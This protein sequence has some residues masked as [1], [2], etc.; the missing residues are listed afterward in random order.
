MLSRSTKLTLEIVL[1][2]LGALAALFAVGAWRLSEGP[3]SLTSLTPMLEKALSDS[4]RFSVDV[5]DAVLAW[6]GWKRTLDIRVRGVTVVDKQGRVI[7][8]VPE[9]AINLSGRA[10]LA[11]MIAPTRIDV[12]GAR[13]ALVR[14]QDGE[15]RL[16]EDVKT[17]PDAAAAKKEPDAEAGGQDS[18]V[19]ILLEDLSKPPDP[20]RV[21]GYL[22]QVNL[23]DAE[24]EIRDVR[25]GNVWRA[26]QAQ[27]SATR[28][29]AGVL[30]EMSLR[31]D[32][33]G[34]VSRLEATGQ[35]ASATGVIDLVATIADFEL[36]TLG[37]IDPELTRLGA[38]KV[39]FAGILNAKMDKVG[40]LKGLSF[41]LTGGAGKLIDKEF[42]PGGVTVRQMR[43]RGRAPEGL[44]GVQLEQAMVD[45]GG[46]RLQLSGRVEQLRTAPRVQASVT[47]SDVATN[48]LRRLWPQ[49]VARNPRTWIT[50]N[51]AN[52]KIEEAKWDIAINS[53]SPDFADIGVEK[54]DGRLRFSGVSVTYLAPM[55]AVRDVD[56][57]ATMNADRMDITIAGGGLG[58]LRV[59]E[60]KIAITD[61]A[62]KDQI[63][64]IEVVVGGP[65]VEM[66]RLADQKPLGFLAKIGMTPED[67]S[68]DAATR[69]ALKFP[70]LNTLKVEQLNV[71]AAA[72]ANAVRMRNAVLGKDIEDGTLTLRLDD[73]GMDLAG[74]VTF[75]GARGDIELTRTFQATQAIVSQT[76]A[77]IRLDSAQ[78]AS[79]GFD[80]RPYADGPADID[81]VMIE[82]R[83][84]R[85]DVNLKLGLDSAILAIAALDWQKPAGQKAA[86]QM[87]LRLIDQKLREISGVQVSAAGLDLRGK[88]QL[89]ADGK[90]L[91]RFDIDRALVGLT[92]VKGVIQRGGEGW[93]VDISGPAF[94][95]G[96]V[97]RDKSPA[98]EERPALA[99]KADIERVH[100]SRAGALEK[101]ALEARR[102][103]ER[104][105][106]VRFRGETEK[107]GNAPNQVRVSLETIAGQQILDATADDGGSLLKIFDVTPNFVG[108]RLA[109]NGKSDNAQPGQPIAGKAVMSE[110]R[111]VKAP[112]LARVL[113]VALLT[114]IGD[115]LRGEGINFSQLEA[116]Y[117]FNDYVLEI[118]DGR[119][120]GS[121]IGIT[122]KGKVDLANDVIDATGT[123]VPA[124]AV[125][126]LLGRIPL[127]GDILVPERGGGL[128]AAN[129][130][131]SGAIDDPKVS[132]NP[133]STITPGFLRGLFGIFDGPGKSPTG[134]DTRPEPGSTGPAR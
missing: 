73:K 104:W 90:T 83:N 16:Q 134:F 44:D 15:L 76:K 46:P 72:K 116:D 32:L 125:N 62:A 107:K 54:I 8:S 6:G 91:T 40:R 85:S 100:M 30:A 31:V 41:D 23:V 94:D 45:F 57:S 21:A 95:F 29:A 115:A 113:S 17:E 5:D 65:L 117:V 2:A 24:V 71:T 61:F 105:H 110:F 60:S 51:L 96:A 56:G 68:G 43:L 103:G 124:Y 50:E 10:V 128:F 67:F 88:A 66:L 98:S 75:V 126:S 25:T 131:V 86:A 99:I 108:G 93:A 26:P 42:Y 37:M 33:G 38:L 39:P 11:G 81:L 7:A 102:V 3:I 122:M 82:Q 119:A 34:R 18:L 4:E 20:D 92:D 28:D 70:L 59:S 78:R 77:K 109:I 74:Q 48:D 27:F 1:T 52:G 13:L 101:V 114:G 133:L 58:N 55:P 97:L 79:L 36:E 112:L 49:G 121:A 132:V 127:V 53:A 64:S 118:K 87:Q 14:T 69:L 84:K 35:Y 106:T 129:Y 9:A 80:F 120:S 19:G 12:I 130:A 22:R 111:V 63:A 89:A 123:L 47:L